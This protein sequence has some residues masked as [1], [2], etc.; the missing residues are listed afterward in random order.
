MGPH[1]AKHIFS[2]LSGCQVFKI[3]LLIFWK[4]KDM[5]HIIILGIKHKTNTL[6][7][8]ERLIYTTQL[9]VQNNGCNQR[10]IVA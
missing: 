1:P 9:Y 2:F 3:I 10:I 4:L 8:T 5:C 7:P 6:I